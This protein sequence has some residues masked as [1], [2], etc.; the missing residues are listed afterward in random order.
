MKRIKVRYYVKSDEGV[1][2]EERY[3]A[4]LVE[5]DFFENITS[6]TFSHFENVISASENLNLGNLEIRGF[7]E[8]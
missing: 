4:T 3:F 1:N 8:I 5:D 2:I 6:D 7:R